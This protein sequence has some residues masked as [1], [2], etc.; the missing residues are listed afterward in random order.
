MDSRSRDIDEC[1]VCGNELVVYK[2]WATFGEDKILV[3]AGAKWRCTKCGKKGKL[4]EDL[5]VC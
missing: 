5:L 1:P 3:L 4:D 2:G